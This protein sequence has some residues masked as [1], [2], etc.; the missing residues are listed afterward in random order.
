MQENAAAAN[1]IIDL[2]IFTETDLYKQCIEEYYE[3]ISRFCG[4]YAG[5]EK[6][7]WGLQNSG[8]CLLLTWTIAVLRLK[9]TSQ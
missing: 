4:A 8:L 7:K 2:N 9:L 5:D 3:E 6:R 1:V